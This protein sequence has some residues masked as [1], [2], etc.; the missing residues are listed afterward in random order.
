MKRKQVVFVCIA[1]VAVLVLSLVVRR[2]LTREPDIKGAIFEE[3][4]HRID[5]QN[6][7]VYTTDG[8][9][10]QVTDY[11]YGEGS[12]YCIVAAWCKD[13]SKEDLSLQ[14]SE[15][16]QR[17]DSENV[18]TFACNIGDG[19]AKYFYQDGITY[20]CYQM[21]YNYVSKRKGDYIYFDI[22]RYNKN[23]DKEEKIREIP[24]GI[25]HPELTRQNEIVLED[26]RYKAYRQDDASIVVYEG[27]VSYH[28]TAVGV[29]VQGKSSTELDGKIAI[30][31]KNVKKPYTSKY[32]LSG[33]GSEATDKSFNWLSRKKISVGEV[34]ALVLDGYEVGLEGV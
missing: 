3:M 11:I 30:K 13:G 31:M 12:F 26:T 23:S 17:K 15:G 27:E 4:S 19:Q 10:M 9:A 18:I 33:N 6:K 16:I 24:I 34:E 2:T 1:L 25:A 29:Y 5:L 32:Y 22:Y 20:I 28:I 8:Y 7:P 21:N 14:A